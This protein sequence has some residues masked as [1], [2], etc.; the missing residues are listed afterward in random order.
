MTLTDWPYTVAWLSSCLIVLPQPLHFYTTMGLFAFL[1]DDWLAIR[2]CMGKFLF[3]SSGGGGHRCHGYPHPSGLTFPQP[4]CSTYLRACLHFYLM[5]LMT[6]WP[7]V[8]AW[9]S[10]CLIVLVNKDKGI[11]GTPSPTPVVWHSPSLSNLHTYRLVCISIWWHWLIGHT[12][13][14]GWVLVW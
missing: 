13:L 8:V 6:D 3:D 10:S 14:H 4:L 11:M 5:T 12:L 2:C 7:S 9:V 1:S